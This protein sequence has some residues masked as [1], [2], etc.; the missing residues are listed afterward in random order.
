MSA[1]NLDADRR[2]DLE[3]ELAGVIRD[4]EIVDRDLVVGDSLSIDWLGFD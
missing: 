3:R 4:F 1:P 2:Q